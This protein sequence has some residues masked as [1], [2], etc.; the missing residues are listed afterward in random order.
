[1]SRIVPYQICRSLDGWVPIEIDSATDPN[2]TYVI[3][4]NP[5]GTA[6]ES[7]CECKSYEFRGQCKHQPLALLRICGWSAISSPEQ[8]GD[9]DTKAMTCPRCGGHTKWEMEVFDDAA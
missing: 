1:M 8:Q 3:L 9:V 2:R 4:V 7:I 6:A 5:W